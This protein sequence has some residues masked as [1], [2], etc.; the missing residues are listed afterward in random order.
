[1]LGK[2]HDVLRLWVRNWITVWVYA[3]HLVAIDGGWRRT[4]KLADCFIAG[5]LAGAETQS[6]KVLR[7]DYNNKIKKETGERNFHLGLS[8]SR[9]EGGNLQHSFIIVWV[10]IPSSSILLPLYFCATQPGEPRRR[11]GRRLCPITGPDFQS[12]Q[13]KTANS[14]CISLF[15]S[16]RRSKISELN[17]NTTFQ[18]LTNNSHF[19]S[20]RTSLLVLLRE[21]VHLCRERRWNKRLNW[22]WTQGPHSW[23]AWRPRC[24]RRPRPGPHK[25][26][27]EHAL[28]H[29]IG[30]IMGRQTGVPP[31]LDYA[32][33]PLWSTAKWQ[34]KGFLG[35]G[36]SAEVEEMLGPF[37]CSDFLL[38]QQLLLWEWQI[39]EVLQFVFEM[40]KY[41]RNKSL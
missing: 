30:N 19:C 17:G 37:I 40:G 20:V 11:E 25:S 18:K 22:W 26:L 23:L 2:L 15:T 6:N 5:R 4:N 35:E 8:R 12:E 32:P 9:G 16:L 10:F 7:K 31:P 21:A 24:R 36:E 27:S 29:F 38:S 3:R 34:I 14:I 39:E 13:N 33:S 28:G 1:M 41:A